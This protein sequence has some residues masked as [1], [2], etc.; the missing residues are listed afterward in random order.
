MWAVHKKSRPFFIMRYLVAPYTVKG[1]TNISLLAAQGLLRRHKLLAI[2]T[3]TQGDK[4]VMLQL[5]NAD[6]Q[7]AIDCRYEDPT[8]LLRSLW[9]VRFIGHNIKYDY[10]VIKSNFSV[11]LPKVRDTMLGSMILTTGIDTPKGYHSLEQCVRRW[12]DPLAYTNQGNL[13][14]VVATKDV[15]AEF[16]T[17]SGDFT[18]E[19][20]TYGLLDVEYAFRLYS[21]VYELLKRE[22]LLRVFWLE[23]EFSMVAG[24]L[25]LK[26][27]PF[28]SEQW[29]ENT[30]LT[31]EKVLE[32]EAKLKETADI[33]WNS[34]AQVLKV[35]KEL[36]LEPRLVDKAKNIDRESVS[37]LAL[38]SLKGDPLVDYYLEFKRLKKALTS[39]GLKF[40]ENV[41][42]K[43]NRIHT[44]IYQILA[45]G[46]T[47]SSDI[48]V[49]NI[50]RDKSFRDCFKAPKN[51]T[52]ITAD[53]SN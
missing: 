32:H 16:A 47:A 46:R 15:R 37:S 29:V 4:I 42:P 51:K 11:V 48:N 25:E 41:N 19:Q 7:V 35:F 50:P 28:S 33:N 13:F 23:N 45:T 31:S 49:Q 40:L 18:E 34:Q 2:D 38:A 20:L 10:K 5:G 52:L 12:I 24:D 30:K 1:F 22:S 26:G 14:R 6:F 9:K 53:Y 21:K 27:L 43:T 39:Y 17:H 3:E 36:G 44:N 8:T